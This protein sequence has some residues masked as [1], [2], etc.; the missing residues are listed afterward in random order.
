M[1]SAIVKGTLLTHA[2]RSRRV[3]DIKKFHNELLK[4][5]CGLR[6]RLEQAE[7]VKAFAIQK[8]LD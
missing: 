2:I 7:V 1:S 3:P 6:P 8:R 5:V 4:Q